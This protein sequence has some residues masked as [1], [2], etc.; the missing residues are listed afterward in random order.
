[1][2]PKS[3]TLSPENQQHLLDL[4]RASIHHGLAHGRPIPVE[5]DNL[6]AALTVKRATFVTLQ[7]HGALRGCIGC[8]EA[9]RSLVTDIAANAY[10]A[11]FRDS[12][13]VPVT[14]DEIDEL[15][16]HLSLL[17]SAEPVAFSSEADVIAQLIPGV[18]GLILEEQLMRGTF[19]PSVWDVLADPR[20]FLQQ[21]KVKAG[22]PPRYW[23]ETI[24]IHRYRAEIIGKPHR[25]H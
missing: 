3:L 1:M 15:E 14:L 18:D 16:I 13:F 7:K 10:A 23:S 4:A 19:L 25:G 22:L 8:L 11:A 17:T 9:L 24:K 6:P 2:E 5:L 21:L 20:D 12:R